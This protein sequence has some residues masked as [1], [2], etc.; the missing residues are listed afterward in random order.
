MKVCCAV[1]FVVACGLGNALTSPSS[2][3]ASDPIGSPPGWHTSSPR[4]E[5]TPEFIYEPKGGVD[6]AGCWV[7]RTDARDGLDGAWTRTLPV[8]GGKYYKFTAW[9]QARAVPLARR[10][11]VAKLDWQDPHGDPVP[12]DEPTVANYLRGSVGMAETEFPSAA[13]TSSN[14][15]TEFSGTYRAPTRATQALVALHLQWARNAEVRWSHITLAEVAAPTP[16]IARLATVHY[17]PKGG[18]TVLDN[19]RQF[20][21]YIAEAARQRADLVVLGETLTYVNLGKQPAEVAETIPGPATTFFGEL[22]RQHNLYI[23]AGLFERDGHLVYNSAVLLGPTGQLV[24]KYR[25]TCLPR[26]EVA[27]GVLP[28]CEY[29]VF[30]TRFGKLGI[31]ICYDGFFPE[32]A[33]ELSNRG[34]EVIA[35]PVWGCNPLLGRARACENH[36]YLV[37]S[38]YED[39]SHNWMLSGVFD[40]SGEVI[41][42]ADQWGTIALAEVDLNRRTQWVSLGDFKAEI[43]RHRPIADHW[44]P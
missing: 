10:S 20:E 1:V 11:V 22:A 28:G 29:P 16:R 6:S 33:R 31:M 34:A 17:R 30:D 26:S 24:G 21:P 4:A 36:V 43:P 15:W 38:T 41:A 9:Y 5:I 12:L 18:K 37:S 8:A 35:W 42:Q 7:I 3:P 14:G 13:G 2:S 32:V 19:C 27:A 40:H 44:S 39:V 25:K 23:V